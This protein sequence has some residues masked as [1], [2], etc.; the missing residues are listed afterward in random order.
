M[1]K[2]GAN[3]EGPRVQA[4]M[5]E[6]KMILIILGSLTGAAL[7]GAAVTYAIMSSS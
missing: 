2:L 1:S 6:T 4:R 3:H 5:T 7:F